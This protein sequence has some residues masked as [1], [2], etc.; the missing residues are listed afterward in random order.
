MNFLAIGLALLASSWTHVKHGESWVPDRATLE[1][2]QADLENAAEW[3][4]AERRL[5]LPDWTSYRF[6]FQGRLVDGKRV[7]FVNAYCWLSEGRS[8]EEFIIVMDGGTC[9]FDTVYDVESKSFGPIG[10]HGE[11]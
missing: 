6:Q 7:V 11:A 8:E 5:E 9:F 10:F 3:A 2:V 4:A 1:V